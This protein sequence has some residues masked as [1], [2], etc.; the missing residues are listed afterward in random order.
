MIR[1]A[2]WNIQ[3]PRLSETKRRKAVLDAI[4]SVQADVWIL[5]ETHDSISPGSN[6][7]SVSTED[8][9]RLHKPGE[10]WV[11]IWSRFPI[12]R[13]AKTSDPSRSLVVRIVPDEDRA[14][15]VYGTVLPWLGSTWRNHPSQ[16]GASF[17]AALS[18]QCTDWVSLQHSN[19]KDNFV[20]A[21]DFNQDLSATH[22]YGSS[23][24]RAALRDALKAAKL[25]CLTS[26]E[27]DPIPKH[28]PTGASIDHI[29]A[30]LGLSLVDAPVSWPISEK[31]L[32]SLSDHFG[33]AVNLTVSSKRSSD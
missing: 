28:S 29:C 16:G 7:A 21:G 33:V 14:V 13:I 12:E 4:H 26:A 5:T 22:Y 2:T 8:A 11:T 25:R 23:R 10:S 3:Q 31:P 27:L 30:G 24:N 9:D 17:A 32:K 19:P 1:I 6:F 15:L 18:A 20:L